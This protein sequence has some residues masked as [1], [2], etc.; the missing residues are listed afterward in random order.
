LA[1]A[2]SAADRYGSMGRLQGE[3]MRTR[4]IAAVVLGF[5]L[6]A[7]A[8]TAAIAAP[9]T[10]NFT[11]A[12]GGATATGSITFESTL[13]ANPGVNSFILPNPAV[14]A[15]TVTVSGATAGNG[16]YGIGSFNEVAFDTHG[17]TLDFSKQLVGQPTTGS[18]WGTADSNGGD[19]NLF[20]AAPA[21]DGVFFFT[22][23]ANGGVADAMVLS[24]MMQASAA[25]VPTLNDWTLLALATLVGGVGLVLLRRRQS[26][27]FAG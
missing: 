16:S 4:I 25:P 17:A 5:G 10:F 27:H 13:L 21:P 18:P 1:I 11:Y 8:V 12:L 26:A 2:A 22:L 24:S 20:G 15:L 9:V 23:G 3:S 7:G 19:F 14:L 6:L